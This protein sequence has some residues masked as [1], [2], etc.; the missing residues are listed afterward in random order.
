MKGAT[1]AGCRAPLLVDANANPDAITDASI[2]NCLASTTYTV[3]AVAL[4][5]DGTRSL[6]SAAAEFTT[7]QYP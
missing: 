4:L 6:A 5:A 3:T 2:A 7:P 1:P